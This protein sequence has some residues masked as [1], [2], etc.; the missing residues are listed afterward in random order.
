[1]L[2]IG[3]SRYLLLSFSYLKCS[4]DSAVIPTS[5]LLSDP[6][7]ES[8]V[9]CPDVT[10]WLGPGKHVVGYCIVSYITLRLGISKAYIRTE[11]L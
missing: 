4:F 10:I 9:A 7:T 1:M 5:Q 6:D 3:L 8:L 11:W 2:P